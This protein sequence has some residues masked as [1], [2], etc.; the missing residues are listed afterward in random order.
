[1]KIYV[2]SSWRNAH[3]PAVVAA[4]RAAGHEVYD[5]RNPRPGDRGFAWAAIDSAW[6]SWSPEAF[7]DALEHPVARAG[8][9]NDMDALHACDACVL[10]LPCGRSAHLELG[11]A[12]GAGK[13]TVALMLA[14]DEPELM[15]R[16]LDCVCTSVDEVLVA[17]AA[18]EQERAKLE[19][20]LEVEAGEA[21]AAA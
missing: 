14:P 21:D 9:K 11:Q 1:V 13:R 15:Y 19:D 4:L 20:L 16:M 7:I 6:Q 17:L 10:V 18:F 12:A 2:A 8:F 5:F 3:Q